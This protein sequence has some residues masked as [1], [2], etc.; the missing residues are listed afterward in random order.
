MAKRRMLKRAPDGTMMVHADLS[1][2]AALMSNDM[3]VDAEGGAL[4]RRLWLPIK[5]RQ[6]FAA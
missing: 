3:V 5:W 6:N 4:C 2:V 1:G